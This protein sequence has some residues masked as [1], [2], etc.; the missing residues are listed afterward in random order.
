M[1]TKELR[2]IILSKK[3]TC[4][5][6]KKKNLFEIVIQEFEKHCVGKKNIAYERHCFLTYKQAE[7]QT[8][9]SYVTELKIKAASCKYG[10]LTESI[11]RDQVVL[12][13]NNLMLQEN[14]IGMSDASLD[15]VIQKIKRTESTHEQ[16]VKINNGKEDN[17]SVDQVNKYFNK[18]SMKG[19]ITRE[20]I[21]TVLKIMLK[22]T[23]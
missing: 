10:N 18:N 17:L 23:K 21:Q 14:L 1:E 11:I 20:K 19:I 4:Q 6:V 7:G 5:T 8:I 2:Y 3:R 9:D 22:I 13:I 12:N 15:K 16:V